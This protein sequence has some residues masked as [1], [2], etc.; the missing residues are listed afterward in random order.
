M[1]ERLFRSGAET[2]VLGVVL[3]ADNL[4]L[5]QVARLAGISAP[6]AKRELDSLR[7]IGILKS[8]RV[9]NL[10]IFSINPKCQ[11]INELRSL[12]MKTDGIFGQLKKALSGIQGI[13][14]AFVYGSVAKGSFRER[15]DLDLFVIGPVDEEKIAA[16]CL[17]VQSESGREI[18]FIIWEESNFARE[19]SMGNSFANAVAENRKLWLQGEE[20][21]FERIVAKA[22]YRKNEKR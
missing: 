1:L 2:K 3:F 19:V 16:A 9:G 6:E 20:D 7:E 13:K 14:Y 21:G 5:R 12:Y 22:P 18:N 8:Q 11:F 10:V 15:S 4:H 17:K